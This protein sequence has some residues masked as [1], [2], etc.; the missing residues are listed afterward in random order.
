MALAI[1]TSDLVGRWIPQLEHVLSTATFARNRYQVHKVYAC[2][3][4]LSQQEGTIGDVSVRTPSFSVTQE[5]LDWQADQDVE[6]SDPDVFKH[7]MLMGD[8]PSTSGSSTDELYSRLNAQPYAVSAESPTFA[9]RAR[10]QP[11]SAFARKSFRLSTLEVYGNAC[12]YPGYHVGATSL[13]KLLVESEVQKVPREWWE[14]F[15]DDESPEL[16]W[17][18]P[19]VQCAVL[20]QVQVDVLDMYTKNFSQPGL[21]KRRLYGPCAQ[22][23]PVSKKQLLQEE[24]CKS[25]AERFNGVRYRP[26]RKRFI[27][28][29]KVPNYPKKNKVSFGDFM[30]AEAAARAIDA[31]FYHYGITDKVNFA[32]SLQILSTQPKPDGLSVDEKLTLVKQHGHMLAELHEQMLVS[33][34]S[35]PPSTPPSTPAV[36]SLTA[37]ALP[38]RASNTVVPS[39]ELPPCTDSQSSPWVSWSLIGYESGD[40]TGAYG[41]PQPP[42]PH[43]EYLTGAITNISFPS[44]RQQSCSTLE[45]FS[46]MDAIT[47]LVESVEFCNQP[48][49]GL[50]DDPLVSARSQHHS[51]QWN[52]SDLYSTTWAR[53]LVES[54]GFEA[55]PACADQFQYLSKDFFPVPSPGPNLFQTD[56]AKGFQY[57]SSPG[58]NLFQTDS[59]KCFQY[60]S[61]PGLSLFQIDS[62]Q[63]FQDEDGVD[64]SWAPQLFSL[65][66]AMVEWS[67]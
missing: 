26:D 29:T 5:A 35:I 61:S 25:E 48:R 7:L 1:N 4:V 54:S 10:G 16:I 34:A 57:V 41:E 45:P 8:A 58:P 33:R 6:E 2:A 39:V 49:Q 63:S 43:R 55:Q 22:V 23:S 24:F 47:K 40:G 30:S 36:A 38:S 56:S 65:D 60:V 44:D 21:R 18:H 46:D 28:E 32:D 12:L 27:A 59:A 37:P 42:Q 11:A 64:G 52:G 31:A 19:G 66:D 20:W 14:S 3:I 13:D 67:N 9:A 15:L 50:E 62:P 53:N 17:A 51:E